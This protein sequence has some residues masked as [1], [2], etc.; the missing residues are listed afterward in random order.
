[1][2]VGGLE[3]R[4]GKLIAWLRDRGRDG[5]WVLVAPVRSGKIVGNDF[6]EYGPY[7]TKEIAYGR[8]IE[9]RQALKKEGWIE[10]P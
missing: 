4:T 10:G 7:L 9:I 8:M 1:M 2:D 3:L 6:V 5:W